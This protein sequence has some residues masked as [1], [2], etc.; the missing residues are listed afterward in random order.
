MPNFET[1]VENL[2][3]HLTVT[4]PAG[5]G[6]VVFDAHGNHIGRVYAQAWGS[7]KAS[8]PAT[9][10]KLEYV[11]G[12]HVAAN[13]LSIGSAEVSTTASPFRIKYDIAAQPLDFLVR[14]P[15]VDLTGSVVNPQPATVKFQ[16]FDKATNGEGGVK[17]NYNVDPGN[18]TGDGSIDHIAV[19]ATIGSAY[20]HTNVANIPANLD[21]CLQTDEGTLCK[22]W[23]TPG[24]QG[25]TVVPPGFAAH[26]LPTD[27]TGHVPSSPVV[28]NGRVCPDIPDANGCD[29]AGQRDKH[30]VI[31]DLKFKTLEAAFGSHDEGCDIACGTVWAEA[32]TFGPGSP[33]EGDHV[34]GR[35]RYWDGGDNGDTSLVDLDLTPDASFIALNKLFFFLH[36]DAFSTDP[37]DWASSGTLTCGDDPNLT[38][39]LNNLP[40]PDILNGTFGVC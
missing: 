33:P 5:T 39:G 8:I 38:I 7:T 20:I 24:V 1:V 23:W 34:N 12:Q 37:L 14:V 18:H 10:Q 16:P 22:P 31:E 13:L 27:L 6:N 28:V 17:I 9:Q 25:Y 2:P 32:S 26:F 3:S 4:L 29:N 15:D 36:Y 19:T 40:D 11:E 35:V 30:V 21:I